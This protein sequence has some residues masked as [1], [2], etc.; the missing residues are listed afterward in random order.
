MLMSGWTS[1]AGTA[2][3]RG[4]ENTQGWKSRRPA[5]ALKSYEIQGETERS[6]GALGR[7]PVSKKHNIGRRQSMLVT[8]SGTGG[9]LLEL[10]MVKDEVQF[11]F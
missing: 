5:A 8:V 4:R 11:T 1:N 7:D 9:S 2:Q 6:H 10:G 3:R